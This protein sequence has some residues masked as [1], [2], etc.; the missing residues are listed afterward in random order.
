MASLCC[1]Y[2]YHH[3]PPAYYHCRRHCH[4]GHPPTTTAGA[5]QAVRAA[6][7]ALPRRL[8]VAI[9]ALIQPLWGGLQASTRPPLAVLRA[10]MPPG[11]LLVAALLLAV[12]AV[13]SP[14]LLT[15]LR[16]HPLGTAT[17]SRG[18]ARLASARQGLRVG[19]HGAA[20]TAHGAS[21]VLRHLALVVP[22]FLSLSLS[23]FLSL[24]FSFTLL[25][26]KKGIWPHYLSGL[27][28]T[29]GV[30]AQ[31]SPMKYTYAE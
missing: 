3:H 12:T 25:V 7:S 22:G 14:A 4:H 16:S 23:L 27:R 18:S 20:H 24:I 13:S 15:S 21:T 28:G 5:D 9:S 31:T 6:V 2:A 1:P 11:R 17:P 26:R 10:S 8:L 29:A 30:H 19:W